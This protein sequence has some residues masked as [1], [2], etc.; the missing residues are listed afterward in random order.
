MEKNTVWAIVDDSGTVYTWTIS[1]TRKA[2][3]EHIL[4][5]LKADDKSNA[6]MSDRCNR[7]LRALRDAGDPDAESAFWIIA[8]DARDSRVVI[9]RLTAELAALKSAPGMAEVDAILQDAEKSSEQIE[10]ELADLARR[11]IASRDEVVGLLKWLDEFWD[12]K[13][14]KR[15]LCEYA[16]D[17]VYGDDQQKARRIIEIVEGK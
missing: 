10:S 12:F 2:V 14:V 15:C 7:V 13:E 17:K 6:A 4:E 3:I 1:D 8:G 9:E 11:S 16:S 5:S